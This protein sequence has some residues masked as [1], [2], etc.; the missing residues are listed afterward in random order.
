MRILRR[1]LKN[2]EFAQVIETRNRDHFQEEVRAFSHGAHRH[3]LVWGGDGTAHAAINALMEAGC[4]AHSE[5]RKAVGFLRGGTGNGIQDSYDVPFS[6]KGQFAT[7]QESLAAGYEIDVDLLEIEMGGRRFYGQLVGYGFDVQVLRRREERRRSQRSQRALTRVLN[8]GLAAAQV[9][10]SKEFRLQHP[11]R[12]H[13]RDGKYAFRGTRINAEFSFDSVT[14]EVAPTAIEAGTRP[15]YGSMFKICPE[16]VC[17]DGNMDV[18]MF[19]FRKKPALFTNISDLWRGHHEHINR[20]LTA[21]SAGV[22]ERFELREM[23]LSSPQPFPFH[24]DGELMEAEPDRT[25]RYSLTIR[26]LPRRLRFIVPGR[27]YR[28]F[29]PFDAELGISPRQSESV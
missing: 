11:C 19:N 12:V 3:L 26:V 22:I 13:L 20:R 5:P 18:Y 23:T 6:T 17:N 7:Y 24:V 25:G 14:R 15:Y 21:R 1:I 8:Y 4:D 10:F 16:A 29:H 28:L 27:F 2:Y 9:Y